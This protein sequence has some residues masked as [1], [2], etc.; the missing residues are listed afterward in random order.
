MGSEQSRT[1]AKMSE[2]G[3]LPMLIEFCS[4]FGGVGL[5]MAST[6]EATSGSWHW[7]GKLALVVVMLLGRLRGL[8]DA[9]DP[10]VSMTVLD[11]SFHSSA[12]ETLD[13]S[14]PS[15]SCF[16]SCVD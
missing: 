12:C 6:P 5:S 4:A 3:F 13:C 1:G 11:E 8:P 15:S 9:I 16:L 2:L 10:S 14:I 7:S